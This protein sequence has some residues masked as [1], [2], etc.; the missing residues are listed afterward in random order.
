LQGPPN[1]YSYF[2]ACLQRHLRIAI[3][4]DPAQEGF[5]LQLEQNP[6]L[7]NRCSML[8]WGGWSDASLRAIA[9]GRL[10][11]RSQLITNDY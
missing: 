5:A 6:A 9:Q 2:L 8:A 3:S 4:L 1:S 10:Q 7:L 11:V